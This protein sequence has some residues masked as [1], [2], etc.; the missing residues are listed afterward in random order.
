MPRKRV[1]P[2][3]NRPEQ[4]FIRDHFDPNLISEKRNDLCYHC[5]AKECRLLP[6]TTKG[7]DCPYFEERPQEEEHD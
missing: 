6:L 7:N 2:D 5:R 3:Y 4:D 1:I